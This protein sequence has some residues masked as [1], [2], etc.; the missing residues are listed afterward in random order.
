MGH[1]AQ[2]CQTSWRSSAA[3][4]CRDFFTHI[5]ARPQVNAP[6]QRAERK[7]SP[8]EPERT[9]RSGLHVSVD[10]NISSSITSPSNKG[11]RPVLRAAVNEKIERTMAREYSPKK[12]SQS[13][14]RAEPMAPFQ[15]STAKVTALPTGTCAVAPPLG[16]SPGTFRIPGPDP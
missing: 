2:P 6:N 16:S 7:G 5:L 13:S 3:R 4:F 11:L 15:A 10:R 8:G 12:G 9:Q 14:P 1:I